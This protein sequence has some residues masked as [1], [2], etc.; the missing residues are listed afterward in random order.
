ME[1][2]QFLSKRVGIVIGSILFALWFLGVTYAA[3]LTGQT[4]NGVNM[5]SQVTPDVSY[6][7]DKTMMIQGLL[8]TP[9]DIAIK[10][11]ESNGCYDK[12]KNPLPV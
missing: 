5:A 3:Y 2:Q 6:I 12:S 8:P 11:A 10:A 7:E 1:K 4:Y 9:K